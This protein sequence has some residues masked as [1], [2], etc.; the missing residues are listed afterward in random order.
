MTT[1]SDVS[2]PKTSPVHTLILG[3]G[4]STG[5][6]P[7]WDQLVNTIEA[8]TK[9][10]ASS[11]CDSSNAPLPNDGQ[12]RLEL[13]W[14]RL[15]E[16]LLKQGGG[17]EE[18]DDAD[19]PIGQRML[20]FDRKAETDWNKTL[21]HALYAAPSSAPFADYAA[22]RAIPGVDARIERSTLHMVADM[23][24][25]ETTRRTIGRV[26]TLNADDW[27]E[28]ELWRR[29]PHDFHDRFR[30]VTHPTFGPS[31]VAYEQDDEGEIVTSFSKIPIV[32]AH[33]F[34]C[35]PDEKD[36][37]TYSASKNDKGEGNRARGGRMPA[38]D[39]PNMLVFRDLDYWR[40]TANPSSFA[41]HTLLQAMASTRCIFVGLS[42][43]D[44]NLLRWLGAL[45]AEHEDAWRARWHLHFQQGSESLAKGNAWARKRTKHVWLTEIKDPTLHR[46]MS[47]RGIE[48]RTV[49]WPTMDDGPR[50]ASDELRSLLDGR[51]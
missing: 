6:V 45:A 40:M 11:P 1:E 34:L 39:A 21:R 30:V 4:V 37:P 18:G 24:N 14:R 12:V 46:Y 15:R 31:S 17:S 41:N 32:H 38:F 42:M 43:R 29:S 49:A 8:G 10:D 22:Q 44:L 51:A 2:A 27:L 35:H 19:Q 7:R 23:L 47:Y 28:F 25:G 50:K 3:A 9:V 48:M 13:A 16:N 5:L 20:E 26:I 36:S 33:G